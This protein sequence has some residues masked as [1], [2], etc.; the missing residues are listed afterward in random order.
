MPTL[1]LAWIPRRGE[2]ASA[3]TGASCPEQVHAHA[4]ASGVRLSDDLL[5]AVHRALGDAPVTEPTLAPAA[6][7]GVK[8]R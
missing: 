1:A 3:S 8:H 5:V 7:T 4:A 2:V 6:R